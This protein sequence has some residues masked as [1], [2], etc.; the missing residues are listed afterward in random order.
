MLEADSYDEAVEFLA[1]SKMTAPGH[2]IV[3]GLESNQGVVLSHDAD[4][5]DHRFELSSV[6]LRC[7]GMIVPQIFV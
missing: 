5:V 6:S 2:F 3:G 7:R 4:V 1:K